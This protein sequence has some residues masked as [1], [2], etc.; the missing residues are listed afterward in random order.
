MDT[1]PET[2]ERLGKF[3]QWQPV[4]GLQ[5]SNP[6]SRTAGPGAPAGVLA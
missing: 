1:L 3:L 4:G 6:L 2:D 5:P